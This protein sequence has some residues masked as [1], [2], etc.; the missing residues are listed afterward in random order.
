METKRRHQKC[1]MFF[2]KV[3]HLHYFF[4]RSLNY[5]LI[6]IILLLVFACPEIDVY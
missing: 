4:L 2:D 5:S 6:L 3:V 1:L